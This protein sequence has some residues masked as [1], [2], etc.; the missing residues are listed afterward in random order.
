MYTPTWQQQPHLEYHDSLITTQQT[1]SSLYDISSG[2][3][4][5]EIE[6]DRDAQLT[7]ILV[8][9]ENLRQEVSQVRKKQETFS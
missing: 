9:I 5:E 2:S 6:V 1:P 3:R 8:V 7:D 4:K